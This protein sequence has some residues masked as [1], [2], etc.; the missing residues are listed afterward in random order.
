M[1]TLR[2]ALREYADFENAMAALIERY[3]ADK[4]GITIEAVPLNLETLHR[5]LFTNH[6]LRSG[7]WDMALIVTDWLADAVSGGDIENLTPYMLAEP[8]PDWPS[9]W[10]R[11]LTEPLDFDGAYYSIPWHDGPEC[12]IYRRDLFESSA[13][14][15]AFHKAYGYALEPPRSWAQFEDI[16]RFFTRPSEGLYGTVFACYPDGHNT[17]Y[18][19]VLQLWSRGG[20]LH[21]GLGHPTLLTPESVAA[22]DFYRRIVCDTTLCHPKSTSFDSVQSGDAFLCGSVAMM[23][24]WFGFASR[25]GCAGG[26]LDGRVSLAPIPCAPGRVPVS[27]SVFWT[28]A[29][30]SGSQH[31]QAAYDFLRFLSTAESDLEVVRHGVVG[32]R[33]STWR[34]AVVQ[35]AVPAFRHIEA[36]SLGARRLPRSTSLPAFAEIVDKVVTDALQS[37][38]SSESI[39]RRAQ[40]AAIQRNIV[41]L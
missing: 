36:I 40:Q 21:D 27:L 41:L 31:K 17:L 39:L 19:F 29:I 33:L 18:D 38:E 14:Q 37:E 5:E 13:E 6:G 34:N 4:P 1:T 7:K 15:A 23:V 16:A 20:D 24:N 9:G 3:M 8:C 11:S 25:A 22:L 28:M 10:A 35:H 2:I 30:G 26:A 12:L 32:V